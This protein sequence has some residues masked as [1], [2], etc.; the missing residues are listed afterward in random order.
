MTGFSPRRMQWP[1]H[2]K[3]FGWGISPPEG[4]TYCGTELL[5]LQLP[6][7]KVNAF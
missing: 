3:K 5:L 6:E 7:S 2:L 4:M 1:I